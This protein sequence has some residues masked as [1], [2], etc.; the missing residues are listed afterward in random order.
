MKRRR[1]QVLVACSAASAITT[2]HS[3]SKLSAVHLLCCMQSLQWV[4]GLSNVPCNIVNLS[5]DH[6]DRVVYAAAHTAVI[7][8]KRTRKQTF[9]QVQSHVAEQYTAAVPTVHR[10]SHVI[11]HLNTASSCLRITALSGRCVDWCACPAG[12]LQR[13]HMPGCFR[14]QVSTGFCRCGQGLFC[15]QLDYIEHQVLV[16][17]T[18]LG[19]PSRRGHRDGSAADNSSSQAAAVA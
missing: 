4:Y 18:Y 9:L 10:M 14:G 3:N 8:D 17:T 2:Q 5:D 16:V 1:W 7:Y 12:P 11:Q 15:L 13:H 19:P 6:N